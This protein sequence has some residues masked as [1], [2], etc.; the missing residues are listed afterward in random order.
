[1]TVEQSAAG[2]GLRKRRR[3]L[4]R[5]LAPRGRWRRSRS[6]AAAPLAVPEAQCEVGEGRALPGRQAVAEL[7]FGTPEGAEAQLPVSE[8]MISNESRESLASD[9]PGRFLLIRAREDA[10]ELSAP[11]LTIRVLSGADS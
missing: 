7:R 10:I 6:Q 9:H 8:G 11:P 4:F 1:M 5:P 2:Q 3:S